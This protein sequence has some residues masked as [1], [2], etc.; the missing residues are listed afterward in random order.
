M[1]NSVL[2][3]DSKL[4]RKHVEILVKYLPNKTKCF[5]C[6]YYTFDV[7]HSKNNL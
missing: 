7:G 1:S 5:Y 6:E 2:F 3:A 4:D